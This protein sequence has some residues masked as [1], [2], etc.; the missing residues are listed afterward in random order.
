M[1]GPAAQ[2]QPDNASRTDEI[3]PADRSDPRDDGDNK[4]H[5]SESGG[6]NA[7]GSVPAEPLYSVFSPHQK[8]AAVMIVSFVAMISPLSGATYY[9]AITALATDFD[10]SISLIQLTITM[11]LVSARPQ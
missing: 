4:R 8:R 10:V 5:T 6:S 11:Y 2:R 3:Q 1:A 7:G 9:P